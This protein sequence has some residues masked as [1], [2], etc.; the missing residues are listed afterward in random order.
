MENTGANRNRKRGMKP[1]ILLRLVPMLL[2]SRQQFQ[3][4]QGLTQVANTV[5]RQAGQNGR[6][7]A[8]SS[9]ITTK[10]C[11]TNGWLK[12]KCQKKNLKSVKK[13]IV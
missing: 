3:S 11:Q 6:S 8:Q 4:S 2:L 10:K 13:T 12:N 1:L 5:R 9:E 7:L